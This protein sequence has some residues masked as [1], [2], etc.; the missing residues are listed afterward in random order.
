MRRFY[1]SRNPFPYQGALSVADEELPESEKEFDS[2]PTL[3]LA[4]VAR[5][6]TLTQ[7]YLDRFDPIQK[8][9]GQIVALRGEAGTGKTHTIHYAQR[10]TY[11]PKGSP[12]GQLPVQLY[13]SADSPDFFRIYVSLLTG[14]D[15][16]T[17]RGIG[18]RF[19]AVLTGE[20]LD[21]HGGTSD[22]VA[23]T[24]RE[25]PDQAQ[26][27][28]AEGAVERGKIEERQEEELRKVSGGAGEDLRRA[29]PFLS[30]SPA[31]AETA[32]KWVTGQA[33]SAEQI[34]QLGV[35]G[36]MTA[37][38]ARAALRLFAR[39]FRRAGRPLIL[40]I[41][42]YENLIDSADAKANAANIGWIQNLMDDAA[43]ENGMV[44]IS[45]NE[46]AWRELPGYIQSRVPDLNL[47]TLQAWSPSEIEQVISLYLHPFDQISEQPGEDDLFPF[48]KGATLRMC[49][50]SGGNI[51]RVL[52]V[53]AA[54]FDKAQTGELLIEPVVV[55]SVL[56]TGSRMFFT[57]SSVRA[58]IKQIIL[59][60]TLPFTTEAEVYDSRIDFCISGP[61]GHPRL[62]VMVSKAIFYADEA[63]TALRH[64]DLIRKLQY[65]KDPA[66]F[67][68]VVLGYVSPQVTPRL[69]PFVH[70]LIVYRADTFR[71]NFTN[72]LKHMPPVISLSSPSPKVLESFEKQIQVLQSSIEDLRR[73]RQWEQQQLEHNSLGLLSRQEAKRDVWRGIRTG[74]AEERAKLEDRISAK[75]AE[76]RL[77]DQQEMEALRARSE[78]ELWIRV[79]SQVL[80]ASVL[81]AGAMLLWFQIFYRRLEALNQ[82][83]WIGTALGGLVASVALARF[84]QGS[85]YRELTASVSSRSELDRLASAYNLRKGADRRSVVRGLR[86][87]NPHLR[88]ASA[89]VAADR[90]VDQEQISAALASERSAIVRQALAYSLARRYNQIS[91]W[92]KGTR[93]DVALEVGYYIEEAGSH[94][95]EFPPGSGFRVLACLRS[96]DISPATL[97]EQ[98][99]KSIGIAGNEDA[100]SVAFRGGLTASNVSVTAQWSDFEVR[101]ASALLNPEDERSIT[102]QY[103]LKSIATLKEMY[104]FFRQIEF[105]RSRDE[106]YGRL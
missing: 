68:L 85:A 42:Q 5:L 74:W 3:P 60:Q 11:R 15:L 18:E 19:T 29:L 24:L 51:R 21:P 32:F 88:Y 64:L 81:L 54:V 79:G 53:A 25:D 61:D 92:S 36:P 99:A 84:F 17:M 101:Q 95:D 100:V 58:E 57:E 39:V 45:G 38:V 83:V 2:T 22:R 65:H 43:A 28:F 37:E 46:K 27:L 4:P 67:L 10:V 20:E 66:R 56:L 72:A 93:A 90:G 103:N 44:V 63:D 104:L 34:R 69:L 62:L 14:I 12:A 71:G 50:Y 7:E 47:I 6:V 86:A 102:S 96:P 33:V 98:L 80:F 9:R 73:E 70:E 26:R 105:V 55:E 94:P 82:L 49:E 23:N 97:A 52:Q 106:T 30:A 35:S 1:P 76:Y 41:D 78:R 59:E 75:H 77:R 8:K 40:C 13:A 48:T 31:M 16:E 87:S 89:L 91:F